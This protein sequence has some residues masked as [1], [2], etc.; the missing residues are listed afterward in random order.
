MRSLLNSLEVDGI[1]LAYAESGNGNPLVFVHGIPTDYRAWNAQLEPFSKKYRVITY[2]RRHAHPNS[3]ES[4]ILEST[5]QNNATDLE[6]L[7]QKLHVSPV[8]LVG[9]SY[10]GFIA[11]Y[12]AAKTPDLIRKLVLIEP[13]IT[14]MLVK[15]EKNRAQMLS[16]LFRSPSVALAA[17]RFT[18]KYYNPAREAYRRGDLD[19]GLK[20]FVDGI[21]NR[22]GALE[23]VP[24]DVRGMLKD[25]AKTLGE[26]ETPLPVF[27]RKDASRISAQTLLMKGVNSNRILPAVVTELSKSIPNNEVAAIPAASH[28]P[29]FENAHAFNDK[30]MEFLGRGQ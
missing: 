12:L 18:S 8:H 19:A 4:N 2:S 7:I 9:H 30:V 25:N 17:G 11:A 22:D 13:G 15:D 3:N 6:G 24:E 23:Q 5:I 29:H 20:F 16:F 1:R 10:G 26:L 28:F 14:T 27:T 21:M